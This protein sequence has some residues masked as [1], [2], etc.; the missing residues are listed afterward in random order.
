MPKLTVN[1]TE[2]CIEAGTIGDPRSCPVAWALDGA[3]LRGVEVEHGYI[4]FDHAGETF[5]VE[6]PADVVAFMDAYDNAPEDAY[7][8]TFDLRW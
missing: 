3:G 5:E 2:D 8:L 4:T 1:V 7:C 6:T